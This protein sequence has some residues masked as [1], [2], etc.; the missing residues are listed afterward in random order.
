MSLAFEPGGRVR[1]WLAAGAAVCAFLSSP[2]LSGTI[3]EQM[4]KLDPEERAHQA[5]AIKGLEVI[6]KDKK[7]PGADRLKA[8]IFGR[9]AYVGNEI[10]AKG[11]AV[12]AK[13]RWYKLAFSCTV[14]PDQMKATAFTYEIGAEIPQN[15]WED[16]G[17][18]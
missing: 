4:A 5:C 13:N 3:K 16:L 12:K 11:G 6:R 18:W 8:G 1:A 17:L 10:T 15:K 2:A 7:L 9:A 14:T